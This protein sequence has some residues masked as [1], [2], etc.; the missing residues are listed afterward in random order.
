ME[1]IIIV[2]T[3]LPNAQAAG[4]LASALVEAR[5]A[6]CVNL[7]PAVQSVYRWQGKVERATEVTLLIKTTQRHYA[8]LESAIRAAHPYDLPEV[9]AVPVA[10]GLPSYLQW[11]IAETA[12]EHHA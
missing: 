1:Q 6:A 7:L 5:L 11:V 4:A 10:A 8:A 3:S 9:I 12:P 2:V